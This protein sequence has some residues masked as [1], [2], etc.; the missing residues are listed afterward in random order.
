MYEK[1]DTEMGFDDNGV[2]QRVFLLPERSKRNHAGMQYKYGWP[3]RL[4]QINCFAVQVQRNRYTHGL[5]YAPGRL[6]KR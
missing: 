4:L 1:N 3:F 5:F 2:K 6:R